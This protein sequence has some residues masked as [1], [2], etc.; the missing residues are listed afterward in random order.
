MNIKEKRE[1]AIKEMGIL[2]EAYYKYT[3]LESQLESL[4]YECKHENAYWTGRQ[5]CDDFE[6]RTYDIILCPDC[7]KSWEER[8]Y[9]G[10]HEYPRPMIGKIN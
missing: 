5:S 10:K 7:M 4:K 1:A 8:C 3:S 9:C 6:G 2:R